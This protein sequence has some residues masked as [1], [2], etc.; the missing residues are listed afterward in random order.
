MST[1]KTS[2]LILIVTTFLIFITIVDSS[3][4]QQHASTTTNTK[5]QLT[6]GYLPAVKGDLKDRQ[7]LSISGAILLALGELEILLKFLH[8]FAISIDL[9]NLQKKSI[10]TQH[11]YQ[12]FT[13]T[14]VGT[15][16]AVTLSSQHVP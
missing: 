6:V 9:I 15:I 14:C 5:T 13:S 1:L 16:L 3:A 4:S 11:F 8:N 10:T 2:F 12:M 7:G